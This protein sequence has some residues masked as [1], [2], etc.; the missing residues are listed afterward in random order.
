MHIHT[1]TIINI[2]KILLLRKIIINLYNIHKNDCY[3]KVWEMQI[4][5]SFEVNN[6]ALYVIQQNRFCYICE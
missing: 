2:H 1:K 6:I 4:K 5:E 3:I